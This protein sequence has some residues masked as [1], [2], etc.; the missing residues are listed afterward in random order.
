MGSSSSRQA[1]ISTISMKKYKNIE[2]Y[3]LESFFLN[4]I[5]ILTGE[6]FPQCI[7]R[8]AALAARKRCKGSSKKTPPKPFPLSPPCPPPPS[9]GAVVGEGLLRG[10]RTFGERRVALALHPLPLNLVSFLGLFSLSR[11][12]PVIYRWLWGIL[13]QAGRAHAPR[14]QPFA[15]TTQTKS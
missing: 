8:V 14:A 2:I 4:K 10:Q 7:I 9:P 11:S 15:G 12:F 6:T 3:V 1:Y 5:P 13:N